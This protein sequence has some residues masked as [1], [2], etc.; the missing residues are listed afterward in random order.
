MQYDSFAIIDNISCDC[1]KDMLK[2]Y[3]NC[4]WFIALSLDYVF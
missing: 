3:S 1:L 2:D 4:S